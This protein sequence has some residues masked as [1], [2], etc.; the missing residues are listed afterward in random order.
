MRLC[1]FAHYDPQRK[2]DPHV[3]HHLRELRK[4][5]DQLVFVTTSGLS[6]EELQAYQLPTAKNITR[7]NAGF[8]F[9]SWKE[10][11]LQTP[12]W[13]LADQILLCNDSIYGPLFDLK[14]VFLEMA[15]GDYDFWGLSDN[16]QFWYHLQS[17][18]LVFNKRL[19]Q[20]PVFKDFWDKVEYLEDKMQIIMRY[21]LG[22]TATFQHHGFKAGSYFQLQPKDQCKVKRLALRKAV[23]AS[24]SDPKLFLNFRETYRAHSLLNKTHYF[25]QEMLD[26]KFPYVKVELMR[27]N[28]EKQNPKA[29]MKKISRLSSYPIELIKNHVTRT[30]Q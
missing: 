15:K 24:L 28:P 13:P 25:W 10:A 17:F 1:F 30:S 3:I 23:R 8:D 5:C 18:F 26:R 9:G 11:F 29:V 2:I 6:P 7:G 4:I 16:T 20:S 27:A 19:I 12:E 22:L 14:T 21:E